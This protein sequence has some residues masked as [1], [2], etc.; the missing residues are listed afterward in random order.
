MKKSLVWVAMRRLKGA[1][2][3]GEACPMSVLELSDLVGF[4]L[5]LAYGISS[6]AICDLTAHL[7]AHNRYVI[8]LALGHIAI[9][10]RDPNLADCAARLMIAAAEQDHLLDDADLTAMVQRLAVLCRHIA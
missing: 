10:S 8:G 7:H 5:D 4:D 1:L 2:N 9:N 6:R 3:R